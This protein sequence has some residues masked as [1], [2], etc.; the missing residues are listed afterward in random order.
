MDSATLFPLLVACHVWG[1]RANQA[2]GPAFMSAVL[3]Y[4]AAEDAV[5]SAIT[6]DN[7]TTP[8]TAAAA[9]EKVWESTCTVSTLEATASA[10]LTAL[11]DLPSN[12]NRRYQ[13]AAKRHAAIVAAV[14]AAK[15]QLGIYQDTY[16]SLLQSVPTFF[17]WRNNEHLVVLTKK[18]L[19]YVGVP[20][21]GEESFP[22]CTLPWSEFP[23]PD[24]LRIRW[25]SYPHKGDYDA[26]G[27]P[28]VLHDDEVEPTLRDRRDGHT[29]ALV[30]TIESSNPYGVGFRTCL[31]IV[32]YYTLSPTNCAVMDI[33][34]SYGWLRDAIRERICG[35]V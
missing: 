11:M 1:A 14:D 12:I 22:T 32:S 13:K 7:A 10:S 27:S 26:D 24:R 9:E 29:D 20:P 17:K 33:T 2:A 8:E 4:G 23:S 21:L 5:R 35:S 6:G 25:V 34:Q 30:F 31:K 16:K 3:N 19:T 15:I 18:G 28:V